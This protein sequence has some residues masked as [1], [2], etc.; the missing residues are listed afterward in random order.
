M[1]GH[2]PVA[3]AHKLSCK[4]VCID[5]SAPLG[6]S[7]SVSLAGLLCGYGVEKVG[8]NIP[9]ISHMIDGVLP[10]LVILPPH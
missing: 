7:S 4:F 6:F 2:D 1:L 5:G 3:V 10:P 9:P 8:I